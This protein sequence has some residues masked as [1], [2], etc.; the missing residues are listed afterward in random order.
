[1]NLRQAKEKAY[2]YLTDI[3]NGINPNEQ[4]KEDSNHAITLRQAFESYLLD[5]ELKPK[6]IVGYRQ[7]INCYLKAWKEKPLIRLDE[8]EVTAIHKKVSQNSKAQAD[9]MARVLRALFNYANREYRGNDGAFIFANNPVKELSHKKQW[10]H[11]GRKNTRIRSKELKAYL[12]AL[13]ET[14]NNPKFNHFTK[15][16]CDACE[17]ALFTGL[18][19]GEVLGLEWNRV[20][21]KDSYYWIDKTKNGKQ[22]ELPITES[23]RRILLRSLGK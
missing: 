9:L 3:E 7:V 20:N 18:R 1:M 21:L 16:V 12:E 5:R 15:S 2:Q 11:V 8:F 23:L 4:R 17:F 14:R 13:K 19:K 6:T 10:N 22:L